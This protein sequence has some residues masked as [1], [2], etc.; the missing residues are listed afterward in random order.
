MTVAWK[1]TK[2]ELKLFLRD[3]MAA[4]FTL[5]FP[6]MMLFL[7]GS[8]FGNEPDPDL[9]GRGQVDVSVPGYIGVIIATTAIMGLPINLAS[10]RAGRILRRFRATPLRPSVVLGAQVAVGALFTTLGSALL[11]L[12]GHLFFGL[13]LPDQPVVVLGAFLLSAASIYALGFILA[14]ILPNA[15]TA[16]S[17]GM[18][19]LFPMMF[20]S[21][22]ALPRP[23]LSETIQDVGQALPLSHVVTLMDDAWT[24]AGW[25]VGAALV[26]AGVMVAGVALSAR[27]FRWE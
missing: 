15:R 1:M 25:N 7:F 13:H 20:L 6:L 26:L 16:Q 2:T 24:G 19:V 21:G 8:V 10:Y 3:P 14:S 9:G 5:V 12:A 27:L 22:A 18:V 17:V 11:V 4:F 23:L